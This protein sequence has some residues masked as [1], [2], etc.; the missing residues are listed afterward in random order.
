MSDFSR[1][2][3]LL[4]NDAEKAVAAADVALKNKPAD[5]GLRFLKGLGLLQIEKAA[6]ARTLLKELTNEGFVPAV[7]VLALHLGASEDEKERAEAL[8]LFERY[9]SLEPYDP[10]GLRDLAMAYD[11]V[12][13]CD[14]AE[15]AYRKA[16]ERDSADT[17]GYVVLM[18][19]L[20]LHDQIDAI[21]SVLVA[22]EKH[23]T[24]GED[25]F[26]RAMYH[27]YLSEATE[28]GEKLARSEPLRMRTSYE[29]NVSLGRMHVYYGRATASLPF[30][31]TSLQ[32]DPKA[33]EPHVLLA[34]VYRKQSRW[35]AALKA[36]QRAI[37]LDNEYSEAY[38]Q[39]ACALTRLGRTKEALSALTKSVELD[40]DQVE[41]MVEETDLK[42]LAK[43]PGFKKLIP[44]PAKQ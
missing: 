36:A 7:Y 5:K 16:I 19:H 44:E 1:V 32:L 22:G 34:M 43:M 42:A 13:E 4:R 31:N 26:G 23:K 33:A 10:R 39:L 2:I 18:E 37:D 8:T 27:L 25:L 12:E 41:F 30:L 3:I 14:K 40:S 24:E 17:Y 6:E 11:K 29:A 35:T 28:A 9:T 20:A 38:Y 21:R 15:A